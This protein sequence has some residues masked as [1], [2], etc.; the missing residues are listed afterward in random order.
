ML[1]DP[2]KLTAAFFQPIV[3]DGGIT[4]QHLED[5]Q[6]NWQE[7]GFASAE[8]ARSICFMV[9]PSTTKRG[10]ETEAAT[11]KNKIIIPL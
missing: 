2:D 11:I 10:R 6:V 9:D 5:L 4:K 7:K 3:N 8:M 1:V